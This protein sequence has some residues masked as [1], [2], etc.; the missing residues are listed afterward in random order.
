[1]YN[2]H[3]PLP[4]GRCWNGLAYVHNE[5]HADCACDSCTGWFKTEITAR[6]MDGRVVMAIH[7]AET[8][9][10]GSPRDDHHSLP[11][12]WGFHTYLEGPES[13]ECLGKQRWQEAHGVVIEA[14]IARYQR[15]Y[16][17]THPNAG[18]EG[19]VV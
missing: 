5:Y 18:W 2:Q 7:R 9:F 15:A 14:A 13:I 12:E 10:C 8:R 16:L 6:S 11:L 1:M 3:S 17:A 19:K 4:D